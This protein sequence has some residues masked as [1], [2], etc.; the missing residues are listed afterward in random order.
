MI[1]VCVEPIE[2]YGGISLGVKSLCMQKKMIFSVGV[3]ENWGVTPPGIL[4]RRD[5]PNLVLPKDFPRGF[6]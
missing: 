6:I 5:Q 4:I 1:V 2:P 3:D